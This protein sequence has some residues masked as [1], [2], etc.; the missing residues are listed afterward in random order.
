[1]RSIVG[2]FLDGGSRASQPTGTSS[3]RLKHGELVDTLHVATE[4]PTL[5]DAQ[6]NKS[7][8]AGESW[9]VVCSIK[10]VIDRF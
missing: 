9:R 3:D 7:R 6:C 5:L 10:I 4:Q 1:M 8:G 2:R